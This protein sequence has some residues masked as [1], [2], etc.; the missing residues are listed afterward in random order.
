ME[1][2]DAFQKV[3]IQYRHYNL[4]SGDEVWV[5]KSINGEHRFIEQCDRHGDRAIAETSQEL[6]GG[7]RALKIL[8]TCAAASRSHELVPST[9]GLTDQLAEGHGRPGCDAETQ[10]NDNGQ[11]IPLAATVVL[12]RDMLRYARSRSYHGSQWRESQSASE[13]DAIQGIICHRLSILSSC[14]F[15]G[16]RAHIVV[17]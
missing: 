11:D 13:V 9:A 7:A 16:G 2:S 4:K 17:V 15:A 12:T 5:M 3:H 10:I 14:R 1:Q 8:Q 6:F